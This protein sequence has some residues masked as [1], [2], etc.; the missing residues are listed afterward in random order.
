MK[1]SP[2]YWLA[3]PLL[4]QESLIEKRMFGCDAFYLHG[5]LQ[6]VLCRDEQEPWSGI[7]VPTSK[8][9]HNALITEFPSLKP[10]PVLGKW[11]Y[12][13]EDLDD[14]EKTAQKIVAR[15]NSNDS[16]I[17]VEPSEKKKSKK[18]KLN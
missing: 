14:F 1:K 2:H 7:L 6:L 15:I 9:S 3:E 10:H 18:K 16:R 17:G 12:L 11:L 4:D 8:E 5:R 13:Q